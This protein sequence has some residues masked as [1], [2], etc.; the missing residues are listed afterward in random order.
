MEVQNKRFDDPPAE[1]RPMVTRSVRKDGGMSRDYLEAKANK[2]R[3]FGCLTGIEKIDRACLGARPGDLWVHASYQG[4]LRTTFALNWAYNLVTQYKTNVFY[5]ALE[6]PYEQVRR[7]IYSIHSANKKWAV[8]G[9]APLDYREVRDGGL[10]LEDERFFMERVIPD[11]DNN[12]NYGSL[13]VACSDEGTTIQEVGKEAEHLHK[14][15]PLGLIVIDPGQGLEVPGEGCDSDTE[16][17]L[18]IREAKRLALRFN[19]QGIPVLLLWQLSPQA[20]DWA[21]ENEGQYL[22]AS[23][24]NE[25]ERIAD[26]VT[27]TYLNH[28]GRARGQTRIS[29][30][31]NRDE[32]PFR[33]FDTHIDFRSRRMASTTPEEFGPR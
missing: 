12:A 32:Q 26:I 15:E 17:N 13:H 23:L 33:P 5:V 11:L 4:E 20:K 25:I 9:I 1:A 30:L 19:H 3:I 16:R 31:K 2:A 28:E 29:N 24:P 21:D 6:M 27:T 10:S 18:V 22:F 14:T 8:E 7:S